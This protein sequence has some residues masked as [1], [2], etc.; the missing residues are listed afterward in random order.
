M[1]LLFQHGTPEWEN[2]SMPSFDDSEEGCLEESELELV[3]RVK[4]Y[5]NDLEK[6]MSCAKRLGKQLLV[7]F[8]GASSINCRKVNEAVFSDRRVV[9]Y[10]KD[11]YVVVRLRVDS[12]EALP[13][14][15][16]DT[17]MLDGQKFVLKTEGQKWAN[18]QKTTLG[19][20]AVP[21]CTKMDVSRS[22]YSRPMRYDLSPRNWLR[23]LESGR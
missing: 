21:M 10:L 6:A 23:W 20:S 8:E 18:Y 4:A 12:R 1:L 11:N 17:V 3:G 9:K 19:F 16:R 5:H 15:E 13:E 22:T 7:Y 2:T 14:N